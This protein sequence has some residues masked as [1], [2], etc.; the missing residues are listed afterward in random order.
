M[1]KLYSPVSLTF[2]LSLC[3]SAG[4]A[5]QC[6]TTINSNVVNQT[7]TPAGSPYCVRARIT[8]TGSLTIQPGVTVRVDDNDFITV[9]GTLQ[10]VGTAAQPIVF[11]ALDPTKP[12]RGITFRD[13]LPGSILSHCSFDNTRIGAAVGLI[14]TIP[15]D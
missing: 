14:N 2:A 4:I 1:T 10:A 9:N 11:T 13:A 12:W 15:Q 6:G 7:W 3:L 8:V 5:A